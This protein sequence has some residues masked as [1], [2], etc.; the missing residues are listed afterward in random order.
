MNTSTS[1]ASGH[2]TSLLI[3]VLSATL[4]SAAIY[5]APSVIE[6]GP[7]HRVIQAEAGSSYVELATGLHYWKNNQWT[8][9]QEVIEIFPE[10]GVAQQGQHQVIF[11]SNLR[12]AGGVVDLQ[13]PDGKRF[14]SA[15]LGLAFTD[16]A[17]GARSLSDLKR[18]GFLRMRV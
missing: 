14:R 7:H 16:R 6:R 18:E 4:T 12:A 2:H 17:S 11:G 5:A 15:L 1:R 10:G 8:E 9:A 13:S 3:A